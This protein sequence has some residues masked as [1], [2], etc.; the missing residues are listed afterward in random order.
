[1]TNEILQGFIDFPLLLSFL[2]NKDPLKVL[3]LIS[4]VALWFHLLYSYEI[5]LILYPFGL[6]HS[7]NKSF[8]IRKKE[9]NLICGVEHAPNVLSR[10]QLLIL[11][12]FF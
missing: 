12:L 5:A 2:V 10:L 8:V 1:M 3:C 9:S 11:L 4:L 6:F 7:S